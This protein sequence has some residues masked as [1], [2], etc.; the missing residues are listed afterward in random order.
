MNEQVFLHDL[1]SGAIECPHCRKLW[2]KDLSQLM[3]YDG[4]NVVRCKC[5][6]GNIFSIQFERRRH[7]RKVTE[8]TGSYVHDKTKVRGLISIRNISKSGAR[9][10]LNTH[11]MMPTG[12]R[13][14]LKF[15]LDD[16]KKTYQCKEAIIKKTDGSTVGLEFCEADQDDEIDT[17][18]KN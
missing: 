12:D 6:C 10:E 8:L 15:N 3:H 7:G 9:L 14:V 2:K 16:A 13:L 4:K 18:C 17:Y 5:P 11:R 1:K